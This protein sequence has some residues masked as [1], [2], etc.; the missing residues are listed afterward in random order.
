[1][2]LKKTYG[3]EKDERNIFKEEEKEMDVIYV[4]LGVLIILIT[5]YALSPLFSWMIN[6]VRASPD[7]DWFEIA[8]LMLIPIL[9]LFFGIKYFLSGRNPNVPGYGYGYGRG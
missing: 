1:M 9:V 6:Y 2:L 4:G 3:E 8:I 7:W 5:F